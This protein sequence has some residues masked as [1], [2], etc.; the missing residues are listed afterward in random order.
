YYIGYQ[1]GGIMT[2]K[3]IAYGQNI[4][5]IRIEEMYLTRAECNLRLNSTVGALP[6]DDLAMINNPDRTGQPVILLP[7]LDDVL[8][9]R[10]LELAFEG[11]NFH[12]ILRLKESTGGVEWNDDLLT[13]PIPQREIDATQGSLVQNPGYF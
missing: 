3:W 6:V 7:T 5:I 9:Q 1:Y 13:L 2:N 8:K 12:D 11:V 10:R 4:P